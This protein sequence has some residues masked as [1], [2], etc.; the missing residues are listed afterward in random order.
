MGE[1]KD[2]KIFVSGLQIVLK[3]GFVFGKF[4][5]IEE[6]KISTKIIKCE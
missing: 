6:K 1:K 2:T 3:F 5:R 4:W